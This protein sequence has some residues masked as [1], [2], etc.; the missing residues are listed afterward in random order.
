MS[1][2]QYEF[3]KNDEYY[4]PEYAVLPIIKYHWRK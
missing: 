3:N 4:T 2:I 1:Q